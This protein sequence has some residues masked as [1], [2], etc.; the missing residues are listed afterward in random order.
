MGSK[1]IFTFA[2]EASAIDARTTVIKLKSLQF[3]GDATRYLF[4]ADLQTLDRHESLM[5]TPIAKSI[6][7][8]LSR[9]HRGKFRSVNITLPS[10]VFDKYVDGDGNPLFGDYL[11][12]PFVY[13]SSMSSSSSESS[14]SE[15]QQ[16]PSKSV[17]SKVKNMV[18]TKFGIKKLNASSWL[19]MFE[20][21]CLRAEILER[22][23]WE[24][25]CL[26]LEGSALEWFES[27][28]LTFI[29]ASWDQWRDSFLDVFSPKG[30]S[31]F[32]SA[33]S[34]RYISGPFSEYA[35]RKEN[36]LLNCHSKMDDRIKISLIVIGLPLYIQE[37]IDPSEISSVSKLFS[38]L[39]SFDRPRSSSSSNFSSNSS[40][41]SDKSYAFN[42]LKNRSPCGYCLKKG[43]R[44]SHPES[45]CR[46]KIIDQKK[47]NNNSFKPRVS[48]EK[49]NVNNIEIDEMISEI[50][51]NQKNE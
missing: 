50:R 1:L 33:V 7:K 35:I 32:R 41:P 45:E 39:N 51:E 13:A 27:R 6:K 22:Q 23:F 26:F 4:P 40:F 34:Y 44:Y 10:D 11:L 28:T 20:R 42:S 46:T 31:D 25:L 12:E 30:W 49:I 24:V 5:D 14:K 29:D 17:T 38:K 47:N 21:E 16:Q 36:L 37:K 8:T 15:L 3:P 43:N 18:L 48:Q 9:E 19:D 2:T